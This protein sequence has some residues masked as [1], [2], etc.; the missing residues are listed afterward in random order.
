MSPTNPALDK[1]FSFFSLREDPF[2]VSPNQRFYFSTSVHDSALVELLWG[3]E[4]RQG[5]LVLTGEAGTGKT[6]LLKQILSW[7]K[8]NHRS[9]AYIF[10]TCLET[11]EILEFIVRD[12]GIACSSSRK[13]DLIAALHQWVIARNAAGD[14]PVLILDEGQVLTIQTLD[15]LRLLLN[16]E[17]DNGKLL[18][19]ILAGQLEL[20][21]KL[22]HQDLH[23]L[24]QRVMMH[25][26]L[27]PLTR[28]ETSRYISS[29]LTVAGT[30]DAKLFAPE[31]VHAVHVCSQGIPRLVNVL[32]KDALVSAYVSQ[33]HTISP[34]K[35]YGIAREL[36]HFPSP[37]HSEVSGSSSAVPPSANS[38]DDRTT[39][40]LLVDR[41]PV[42]LSDALSEIRNP[43]EFEEASDLYLVEQP[44]H[45]P[46]LFCQAPQ[47]PSVTR[48]YQTTEP[49]RG[50][51]IVSYWASASDRL[52]RYWAS[53]SES[54]I[55][56]C[57]IYLEAFSA[58]PSLPP[59]PHQTE[60]PPP[61]RKSLFVHLTQWLRAP[62][63]PP[64]VRRIQHPVRRSSPKIH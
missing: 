3:I 23:Q 4:S 13:G 42:T 15:E 8:A 52:S 7:L 48:E 17:N 36:C 5:F 62:V 47:S 54:F 30:P 56:D 61:T 14:L 46:Q 32:C 1:L 33:E 2:H 6:T 49:S 22:C 38:D 44:A 57:R 16:L 25:S 34:E 21:E 11:V 64:D 20:E 55:R 37:A 27:S 45:A 24:R 40:S 39:P 63:P 53:V 31:T 19:I 9:S 43:R 50:P 29:R 18:Q 41:R 60:Q 10:H 51:S 26:R 28:E 59:S 35:I 58:K 12:F